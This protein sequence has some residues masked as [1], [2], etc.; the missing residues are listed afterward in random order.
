MWATAKS[1]APAAYD[2]THKIVVIGAILLLLAANVVDRGRQSATSH[3]P[4]TIAGIE[5]IACET[6]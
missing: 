1:K 4:K 3:T 5:R 6:N 2:R